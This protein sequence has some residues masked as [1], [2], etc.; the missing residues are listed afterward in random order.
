MKTGQISGPGFDVVITELPPRPVVTSGNV[1]FSLKTFLA[2][3]AWQMRWNCL[4]RLT[5]Q[6]A[7]VIRFSDSSSTVNTRASQSVS[8]ASVASDI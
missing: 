5:W 6:M 8:A 4:N 7:H 2:A 1:I 3:M